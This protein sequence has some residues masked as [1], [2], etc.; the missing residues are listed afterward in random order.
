[1]TNCS[2]QPVVILG[3]GPT[4]LGA[5]HGL[6]AAGFSNWLL[7]E[8][9]KTPG[10]LSRSFRD[11]HGFTWDIGGHVIFSHYDEFTGVLDSLFEPGAWLGHVREC[12]IR[13][14][15]RWVPYPFQNN[16]RYLPTAD[17]MT[18]IE[19]VIEAA[20]ERKG[21][22]FAHFGDFARR[23][24]GLG[25]ANLFMLP[26][27]WKVWAYRPEQL[28]ASWIAERVSVPDPV[29]VVRN[30]I[31]QQDD[32]DWGPNSRFRF[33]AKGGTGAIWSALAGRLPCECLSYQSEAVAI[34]TDARCFHCADGRQHR[35]STLIS[36]I[37]LDRLASITGHSALISLASELLHSS[38]I[39]VGVALN[40]H[41]PP[42]V[43]K[44]CWMYFPEP[45]L[46]FYRVTHFSRYSHS[47]VDDINIHWS[48][49]AEVSE[50]PEKMADASTVVPQT[51]DGLIRAG[52]VEGTDQVHHTWQ[53][54]AEYGYPTPSLGR[55]AILRELLPKL[56]A[57]GIFSRGRFGT[58]LYEVGNMD[59]AFMQG[60]EAARRMLTGADE[61]TLAGTK[62]LQP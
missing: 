40:G 54:R 45:N 32:V 25:I 51:I 34:D 55:N 48:V 1:M 12:W 24:F 21:T 14:R 5:A 46:P 53:Y 17:L 18:C 26:Y 4:G 3:A 61:P 9:E 2:K 13:I 42:H 7:L 60:V 11:E 36:T 8:R 28:D 16:I 20:I 49:M 31:M 22:P 35:Y 37:P 44:K 27:N 19:G 62:L 41:A 39:L 10:G 56:E 29:R 57:A 59:H 50:S 15:E 38:V 52:L 33:P 23:T 47:N 43:E 30:V 6:H 58:W